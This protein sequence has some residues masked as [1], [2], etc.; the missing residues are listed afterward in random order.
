MWIDR[1]L[2]PM[3][4]TLII[5]IAVHV[6]SSTFWAGS[7]FVL[8]R[9]G[10]RGASALFRPQVAAALV[11]AL[12]GALLWKLLH[13]GDFGVAEAVLASGAGAAIAS[14]LLLLTIVRPA[15]RRTANGPASVAGA[16]RLAAA[17]LVITVVCMAI[18][19]YV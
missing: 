6:L 7:T 1:E 18:A 15:L 10:G 5:T 16:Y 17:L 12:S 14:L 11:S 2:E 13:G 9:T 4:A 3:Q 19:R 8:A